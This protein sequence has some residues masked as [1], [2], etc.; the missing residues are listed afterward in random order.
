MQLY[1][2]CPD[3]ITEQ[4]RIEKSSEPT[5]HERS[6]KRLSTYPIQLTNEVSYEVKC[7]FGHSSAI[8]INLFKH[9]ILFE[10]GVHS[11]LDGYYREAITSFAASLE[12]FYEFASR[13]IA[14]HYKL[15]NDEENRCWKEVSSQSERQLGAYIY[16]HAIHFKKQPRLLSNSQT[17]LRNSSVHKGQIPTYD[18]AVE[19]GDE[20][21][22]IIS[23]TS[24]KIWQTIPEA[25]NKIVNKHAEISVKKLIDAGGSQS[26]TTQC[27]DSAITGKIHDKRSLKEHLKRT[28]VR[29]SRNNVEKHK[30]IIDDVEAK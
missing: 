21:L 25:A 23:E 19:F 30:K 24:L 6:Q 22:S 1:L 17:A 13:S 29:H 18:E 27:I 11:I 12:R 16:L 5:D 9:E 2:S 20:A 7:T 8:F 3:C 26:G 14:L 28:I 10:I 4:A 15:P